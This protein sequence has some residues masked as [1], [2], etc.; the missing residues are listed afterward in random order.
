MVKL[1]TQGRIRPVDRLNLASNICKKTQ[2]PKGSIKG[3]HYVNEFSRPKK[4]YKVSIFVFNLIP[5]GG[6][7]YILSG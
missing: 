1:Q 6:T 5:T 7:V 2:I 3:I 4:Y